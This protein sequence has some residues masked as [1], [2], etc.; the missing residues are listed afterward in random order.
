[1]KRIL[2]GLF[3]ILFLISAYASTPDIRLYT[4]DCGTLEIHDKSHFSD[5]NLYPHKPMH[6]VDPCFLVKHQNDWLLWDLGLGDQYIDHPADSK[7]YGS[8]IIVTKSLITQLKQLGLKP[9]NIKYVAISHAHFDHT[10]NASLF[11]HAMWLIQKA[12]YQFIQQPSA[13]AV[14]K[15]LFKILQPFPKTLLDGDDD[16]FGDGTVEI[17]RTP[18][19]T[20]GHQCLLIRLPHYGVVILSGDL[21]HTR[22]DYRLKQIPIF[23]TSRAETLA[24]MARI[25]GLLKN[26]HGHLIIQHDPDDYAALPKIPKYLD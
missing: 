9:D 10:G 18:G 8:K 11:P 26:T 1:M 2:L 12:E 14:P 6:L 5:T 4:L 19:H 21:Y 22:T 17:I 23:N 20:P 7:E 13:E 3:L 25:D 15:N 16:V 24:S